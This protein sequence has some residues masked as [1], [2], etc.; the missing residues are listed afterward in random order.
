MFL[1]VPGSPGQKA[2]KRLC[3]CVCVCVCVRV[4]V[5]VRVCELNMY[6]VILTEPIIICC[7]SVVELTFQLV[8]E[9]HLAQHGIQQ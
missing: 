3:V 5:R 2:I 6:S 1:L 4:R 9:I 7:C 8:S